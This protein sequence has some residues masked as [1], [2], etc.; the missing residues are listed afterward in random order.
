MPPSP[1]GVSVLLP[2]SFQVDEPS[3]MKGVLQQVADRI[4]QAFR[5]GY[6]EALRVR[7]LA[8]AEKR[9]L[10]TPQYLAMTAD[11]RVRGEMGLANPQQ[12]FLEIVQGIAANMQ[13]AIDLARVSGLG[14]TGGVTVSLLRTDMADVLTLPS[15]SFQSEKGF[16]VR[17]LEWGLTA[18]ASV[19]VSGFSFLPADR[20]K[21]R[22]KGRTGLGLM[23]K[24]GQG[25]SVPSPFGANWIFQAFQGAEAVIGDVMVQELV[26]R[27]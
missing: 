19:V 8:E 1:V 3:L 10:S 20:M 9:I 22:Y 2:I 15:S 16:D 23:R 4:N 24:G 27:L 7:V 25:W 6:V 18:G 11:P 14:L 12:A 26:R 13:V 5:S 21:G 17:W